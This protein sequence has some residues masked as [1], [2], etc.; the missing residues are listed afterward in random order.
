[1][2]SPSKEDLIDTDPPG[3]S[4]GDSPF[5]FVRHGETLES[6]DG[7]VQGQMDTQ[8]TDAGRR[9]A[10]SV[11]LRLRGCALGSIYSSPLGR[12][13]ETASIISTQ[14]GTPVEAL[15][16]LRERHWGSFQGRPKSERPT[17]RNPQT[18]EPLEIFSS[19][20]MAALQSIS[21]RLPVLVVAHS[22]VFRVLAQQI[23]LPTGAGPSPIANARLIR[24]EPPRGASAG[25]QVREVPADE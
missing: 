6:R 24:I 21:G 1:M 12:A 22:G 15:P 10:R 7:I 3:F 16:G 25:W 8:L 19:R 23:G 17:T 4:F 13:W 5:F 9:S 18:A 11:G 2:P 20:V 14:T